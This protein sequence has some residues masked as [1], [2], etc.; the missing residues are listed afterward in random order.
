MSE[1][2]RVLIIGGAVAGASC[3]IT[4]RKRGVHVKVVEKE[5]FPRAKVCGCCIGGSGIKQLQK[6]GVWPQ[7]VSDSVSIDRWVGFFD[8]R[9]INLPI[10]QGVAISRESLDPILLDQATSLGASV[11]LGCEGIVKEVLENTTIVDLVSEGCTATESFDVVVV[12]SGLLSG[13]VLGA[14]PWTEKP[15]G[16]FGVSFT[17]KCVAKASAGS[18]DQPISP[19]EIVMVCDDDGYVGLV[20]LAD[21]RTDIAAALQSGSNAAAGGKPI[22]RVWALLDRA[23]LPCRF[24]DASAVM[25]TPP[26]RRT[27]RSGSGRIL[28]IGDAAGYVEPFTGEGMTWAMESGIAAGN[29]IADS[30]GRLDDVPREQHIEYQGAEHFAVEHSRGEQKT[31]TVDFGGRWDAELQQLLSSK[32]RTCRW[33]TS[34]IRSQVARTAAARTLSVFPGLAKPLLN[35]LAN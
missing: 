1:F 32:K 15:H 33:V 22:D 24:T 6:L 4:L 19:G 23:G 27:R 28:A 35:H 12:A 18:R 9:R 26:L 2:P 16:P 31:E 34:A 14:L 17:A 11:Q 8:G 21:G 20:Q 7:V 10:D 29:L 5:T 30:L 3:A 25:T 13:D